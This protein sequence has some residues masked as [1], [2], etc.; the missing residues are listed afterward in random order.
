MSPRQALSVSTRTKLAKIREA[1]AAGQFIAMC[2]RFN[3]PV[4]ETQYKFQPTRKWA[5]DFVWMRGRVALEC[6]G[7]SEAGAPGRHQRVAGWLADMEKYNELASRGF[8]LFR[9]V[10][11]DLCNYATIRMVGAALGIRV[12]P[13]G[14]IR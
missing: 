8:L 4:P 11:K 1:E 9:V 5:V 10:P 7:M 3:L 2:R 12:P 13:I 14:E 6:E